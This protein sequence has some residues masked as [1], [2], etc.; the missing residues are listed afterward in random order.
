MSSTFKR[1][2]NSPIPALVWALFL[3]PTAAWAQAGR[4]IP[5]EQMSKSAE[6]IGVATI[7]SANAHNEPR[8]GFINTDLH[9]TFSEVWKGDAGSNFILIKPGGE[10]GGKKADIPGHEFEIALGD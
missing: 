8:T 10:V 2:W 5:V 9:L 3:T 6:V 7:D 1:F 4:P